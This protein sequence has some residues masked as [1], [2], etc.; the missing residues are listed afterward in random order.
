MRTSRTANSIR[1]IVWSTVIYILTVALAFIGRKVFVSIFSNY[2]LGITGV[3][4]NIVSIL[5]ITE[6]GLGE[7]I[8]FSLYKP[9]RD[10]DKVK[11]KSLLDLYKKA[12]IV[13][14][15]SILAIS[16]VFSFFILYFV[17]DVDVSPIEIYIIYFANVLGVLA[18]Y[19][20]AHQRALIIAYQKRFVV[21][22][23]HGVCS[24]LMH[25]LQI[26]AIL[27]FK[28]YFVYLGIFVTFHFV[29]SLS[30]SIYCGI[31]YKDIISIKQNAPLLP[32]EKKEITR[33]IGAMS[34]HKIG[35]TLVNSTDNL[36]I[37]KLVGIIEVGLY[38]NY[39][40]IKTT[41][42]AL[43][44]SVYTSIVASMGDL[45][46]DNE[47]SYRVFN[48]ILY[49][50]FWLFGWCSIC[51][52]CLY[53]PFITLWLGSDFL[54]S[55]LTVGL[56][57]VSF[58]LNCVREPVLM[59]RD[60]FGLFWNDRFKAIFEALINLAVSIVLGIFIGLPGIIIGTIVS[61]L[62]TC[63]WVE[64]LVLYKHGFKRSPKAYFVKYFVYF[65]INSICFV[66]TF[67]ACFYLP[68][69]GFLGIFVK[70]LICLL[71]PNLVF[72]TLTFKTK[73]FEYILN[74]VMKKFKKR[75]FDEECL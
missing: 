45:G 8:M 17:G 27:V 22:I 24:V 46:K 58:Y 68:L 67:F 64:P 48:V 33:N 47:K 49:C 30:L 21:S 2:Y 73:E 55:D 11:I 72:I 16:F 57:V 74:I 7:A 31:H 42:V 41:I 26:F 39:I 44:H 28:N 66:V 15:L 50:S 61:N 3:M 56:I 62:A 34:V 59:T 20:A 19:Y 32:E 40:L 71:L 43:T 14:S 5:S 9:I 54:L 60:A 69:T 70:F 4:T 52:I 23:V 1:N 37:S 13:I 18:S 36:L 12:Y 35:G 25:G 75:W 10:N 65:L 51:L 6:L 53:N 63:F 38:S 29:E